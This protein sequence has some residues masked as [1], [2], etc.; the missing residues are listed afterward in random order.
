[1]K[2]VWKCDYCSETSIEEN[3]MDAHEDGCSFN[4]KNKQ[5]HSCGHHDY[6]PHTISGHMEECHGGVGHDR[7]IHEIQDENEPC[8]K[9][10]A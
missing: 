4:P 6:G 2:R 9:W 5:C 8:D 10:I 1:M 3:T 7:M